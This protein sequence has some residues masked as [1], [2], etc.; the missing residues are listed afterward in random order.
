M[1]LRTP[2]LEWTV[3]ASLF[4]TS[5]KVTSLGGAADFSIG[6]F[7]WIMKDQSIPVIRTDFCV[8]NP[9]ELGRCA[10]HQHQP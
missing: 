8:T 6:N 2:S 3:G 10:D 1:L 5:D 4:T 9:E 7:G